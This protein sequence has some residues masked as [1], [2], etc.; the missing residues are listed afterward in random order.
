VESEHAS[1]I[2]AYAKVGHINYEMPAAELKRLSECTPSTVEMS[3]TAYALV[4]L[5]LREVGVAP[6]NLTRTCP[7]CGSHRHGVLSA[8]GLGISVS[9]VAGHV[10]A[11][12]DRD[13][14]SLGVDIELVRRA[15]QVRTVWNA[16]SQKVVPDTPQQIV[17]EWTKLEAASKA[18]GL[19]LA[20]DFRQV[21][22]L[23]GGLLA[24]DSTLL[25]VIELTRLPLEIIG[26]AVRILRSIV[27]VDVLSR[28]TPRV[29][30]LNLDPPRRT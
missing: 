17:C 14:H 5:I 26:T 11:V 16:I 25:E 8:P 28:T 4:A 24:V 1:I 13:G 15:D 20:L 22:T 18:M 6:T 23:P 9:H 21:I 19:G 29:H 30:W 2:A 7:R 10:I 12:V 3:A 27:A